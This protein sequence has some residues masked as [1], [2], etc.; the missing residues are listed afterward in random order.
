MNRLAQAVVAA[1]LLLGASFWGITGITTVQPASAQQPKPVTRTAVKVYVPF[2]VGNLS[3]GLVV[4]ETLTGTCISS[5]AATAVR[6]DA[7]RCMAGNQ[8]IDPCFENLLGSDQKTLACPANGP[9]ST[10]VNT[11]KLSQALPARKGDNKEPLLLK[12]MPWAL[13]LANGEHCAMLTGATAPTAGMRIN[14]GCTGGGF[15]VGQIE[16]TD[17]VWQIFYQGPKAFAL[18]LT[19]IA[20]AWY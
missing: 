15:A 4:K 8:I 16:R 3:A 9:W 6:P 2:N 18:E 17:Q 7:W 1:T 12:A 11:F 19:D 13:E 10:D 14:Y 20:T 5:S